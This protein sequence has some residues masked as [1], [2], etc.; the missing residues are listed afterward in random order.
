MPCVLI[1]GIVSV[2]PEDAMFLGQETSQRVGLA[3]AVFATLSGERIA[4]CKHVVV[5]VVL[6]V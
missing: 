2:A 1:V 4:L 3:G 5:V 6:A